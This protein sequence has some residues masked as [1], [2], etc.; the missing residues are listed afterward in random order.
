MYHQKQP[1]IQDIRRSPGQNWFSQNLTDPGGIF[2]FTADAADKQLINF[3]RNESIQMMTHVAVEDTLQMTPDI[4]KL[5]APL[6]PEPS[7]AGSPQAQPTQTFTMPDVQTGSVSRTTFDRIMLQHFGVSRVFNG[8]RSDQESYLRSASGNPG[9]SFNPTSW[10]DW[11]PGSDSEIYAHIINAFRSFAVTFGGI[12]PVNEIGFFNEKYSYSHS[13]S[14]VVR[15][16]GTA[17]AFG[18]GKLLIYPLMTMSAKTLPSGRS[19][20]SPAHLTLPLRSQTVTRIITHELGHGLV[21]IGLTPTG[22]TSSGGAAPVPQLMNDYRRT[23]GWTTGSNP[24]LYD[25]GVSAVQTAIA[26]GRVPDARYQI[27]QTNWNQPNWIEQPV[28]GYM[29]THPSEDFP[30]AIMTYVTQPSLLQ[31][32]SPGRFRFIR[33]RAHQLGPLLRQIVPAPPAPGDYPVIT[34]DYAI[35]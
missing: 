35:V 24:Q 26:A 21:E 19:E 27:N 31:S 9:L 28:T 33:Q 20:N 4:Q 25:I 18:G 14:G 7:S 30:E 6:T 10:T 23:A 17:A 16:R 13:S 1:L 34:R 12:P 11:N 29:T 5:P 2:K 15:E 3:D 22:T 32:R 8:T